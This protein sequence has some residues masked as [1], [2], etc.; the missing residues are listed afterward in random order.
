VRG[1]L[2]LAALAGLALASAWLLW[3]IEAA[4]EQTSARADTGPNLTIAR[5]QAARLNRQGLRE[6]TL[7]APQLEQLPGNQGVRLR[8]PQLEVFADDQTRQWRVEAASGWVAPDN[9]LIRLEQSVVL[10]RPASS[11][12]LPV[13][14]TTTE[15]LV[16]PQQKW[17]ET[18]APV[19]MKTPTGTVSAVGLKGYF[20]AKRLEL[21]ADVQSTYA[22]PTR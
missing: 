9:S 17:V 8:Q 13:T 15:L 12:K 19:Q 4:L 10:S 6:Y 11:G 18:A 21:L 20:D 3:T 22:P 7:T 2:Y 5:F 1:L 16:H 14:I